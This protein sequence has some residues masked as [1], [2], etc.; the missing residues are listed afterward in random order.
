[1]PKEPKP[2]EDTIDP[3]DDAMT[4]TETVQEDEPVEDADGET[5]EDEDLGE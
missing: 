2:I 4:A 5:L 3:D 1:M